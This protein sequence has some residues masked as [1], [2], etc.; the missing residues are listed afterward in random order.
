MHNDN[1]WADKVESD[2]F[3]VFQGFNSVPVLLYSE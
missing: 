3:G 2:G 1:T